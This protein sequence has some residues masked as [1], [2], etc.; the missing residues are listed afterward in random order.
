SMTFTTTVPAGT[1]AVV[2]Y[3]T[4]NSATPD[5]TW[6]GFMPVPASGALSGTSRYLQFSIQETTSVPGQTPAVKDVTTA[7]IRSDRRP[8]GG[9]C[10][11]FA[12]GTKGAAFRPFSRGPRTVGLWSAPFQDL[13]FILRGRLLSYS[14][15]SSELT[16][17]SVSR[18]VSSW[19]R[20]VVNADCRT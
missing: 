19:L 16:W 18:E 14:R 4:G 3:R 17:P 1:T 13:R 11:P 10:V 9:P 6:T 7:F 5:P 20:T 15:L 2:S 8:K 12:S